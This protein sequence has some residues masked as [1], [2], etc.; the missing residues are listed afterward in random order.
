MGRRVSVTN[1][2]LGPRGWPE[3]GKA[4]QTILKRGQT[5][6]LEVP[7]NIFELLQRLSA[8]DRPEVE[9]EDLGE[10]AEDDLAARVT[11]IESVLA[12]SGQTATTGFVQADPT[13]EVQTAIDKA[14]EAAQ[15]EV[16]SRDETIERQAEEIERLTGELEAKGGDGG[17]PKTYTVG[18][19]VS[20]VC[21]AFDIQNFEDFQLV[22]DAIEAAFEPFAKFDPDG[23]LKPGG[24]TES[25]GAEGDAGGEQKPAQ[26]GS[27]GGAKGDHF[28]AMDDAALRKFILA[29]TQKEPHPNA[30]RDTLLKKAREA[31]TGEAV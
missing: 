15:A 18:P 17:E 20:K 3:I 23:D 5:E 9:L 1:L 4:Q 16:A 8:G 6:T 7:D 13:P 14:M 12:S 26:T 27:Q 10:I 30:K 24:A 19:F 22:L 11:S 25:S 28:D 29:Q 21:E 2:A 31:D